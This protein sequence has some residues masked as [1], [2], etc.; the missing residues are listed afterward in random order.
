VGGIMDRTDSCAC[1]TNLPGLDAASVD[2]DT[3]F[4]AALAAQLSD[5]GELGPRAQ[6]MSGSIWISGLVLGDAFPQG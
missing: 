1:A 5:D 4:L 6:P 3:V 2:P